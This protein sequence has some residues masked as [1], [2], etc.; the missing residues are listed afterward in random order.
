M[1]LPSLIARVRACTTCADQLPDTPRPVV[2]FSASS[3]ILIAGQAPGRVARDRGI[4]FDDASGERLRAWLNIDRDTFYD[5]R[6]VAV[7]P[8]AFCFPGTGKSGDAPPPPVCAEQWR[9][10]ILSKLRQRRLTLVIGRYAM[11]WHFPELKKHSLTEVVKRW[12][13]LPE[14]YFPLPHPS[15]RNNIWLARNPWF[16]E[17]LLPQLRA[18]VAA[19]LEHG[20]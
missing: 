14:N 1:T 18:K 13:E 9:H 17:E 20:G 12:Q 7:V 15:P 2:Q 16:E 11:D 8:M 10:K 19:A 5:A 3:L 6:K 4:P